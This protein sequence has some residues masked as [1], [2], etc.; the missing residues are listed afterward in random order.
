MSQDEQMSQRYEII[1]SHETKWQRQYALDEEIRTMS[2]VRN[3]SATLFR[4]WQP[5]TWQLETRA[6]FF[7]CRLSLG[8]TTCQR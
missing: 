3:S 6:S 1:K 8:I 7:F 4:S 2:R 5:E